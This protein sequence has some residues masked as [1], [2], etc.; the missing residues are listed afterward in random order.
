MVETSGVCSRGSELGQTLLADRLSAEDVQRSAVW[1]DTYAQ[2]Q[3]SYSDD[4]E[5]QLRELRL[6]VAPLLDE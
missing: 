1:I 2:Q 6:A 4:Q 3:G 5:E